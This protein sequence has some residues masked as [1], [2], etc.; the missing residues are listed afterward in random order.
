VKPSGLGALVDPRLE[1]AWTTFSSKGRAH[2]KKLSSADTTGANMRS[3]SSSIGG[4]EV[5]NSEMGNKISTY[6][7]SV[8]H[9]STIISLEKVY[10]ISYS[11]NQSGGMKK[12]GVEVLALQPSY[13]RFK[14]P[15]RLFFYQKTI[16]F[17][18]QQG[19]MQACLRVRRGTLNLI[20]LGQSRLDLSLDI[21]KI[22]RIPPF[23]SS[24]SL[25]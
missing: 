10:C 17:F 3:N 21:S 16:K 4:A 19:F 15:K 18:L 5:E 22:Q 8:R 12:S 6:S 25:S 11:P 13:S 14:P 23:K 7:C 1:R 24:F 2:K 20:N 9:P